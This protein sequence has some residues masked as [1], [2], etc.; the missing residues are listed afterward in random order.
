MISSIIRW[1]VA[2]RYLT[3]AFAAALLAW[4]AV[5]AMRMPVD[6]FPDLTAPSVT[7]IAEAHGMAP[8]EVETQITIPIE[9]ALNGAPGV[10]RTRSTTSVG[11]SV[12]YADFDWGV[13]PLVARQTVSEKLQLARASLPEDLPAPVLAPQTSVM[14]EIMFVALTSKRPGQAAALKTEADWRIRRRLLAVPGVAEVL[15]IGGDERQFQVIAQPERLAAYGLTISDVAEAARGASGSSSEGLVVV[16]AQEYLVQ[17]LARVRSLEDLARSVVAVRGGTPVLLSDVADVQVGRALRRGAGSY[18]A[19]PAVVIGIAK[20]PGTDTLALTQ[21]LDRT[22]AELQRDLPPGMTIA[23]DGFRQAEFINASIRNLEHALRDG[24][25]LV[26]AVVFLFLMSARATFVTLLAIPLSVLAAALALRYAG[27]GINTMTLGGLAIALG[28]LVDDAIIVV[29]NVSRRLRMNAELGEG[30][31]PV[32][33]VVVDATREIQGSIFFA[34][35]IIVLVFLP[36]FALPGVEGRLLAPLALA[37]VVALAASFV[38]AITAT[39][40]LSALMLPKSRAAKPGGEGRVAH[41]VKARYARLLDPLLARWRAAAVVS[42]VLLALAAGGLLVAGRGFLPEFNEGSFT[43][44]A[45]TLPGTSLDQSDALGRLVERTIREVPEVRSTVRRTGRAELDAH[46]QGVEASEID[47]TMNLRGGRPKEA[48]LQDM[49]ERL[50]AVA[51]MNIVIGQPISHRIDHMLSGTRAA[52]AVKVF[53]PDLATLRN[54]AEQV[55]AAAR[56]VPGIADLAVEQQTQIPTLSVAFNREALATYGLTAEQAAA[57][58]DVALAGEEVGKVYEGVTSFNI[59]VRYGEGAAADPAALAALPIPTPSG[60]LVP[61][62]AL[63]EV[64]RDRGPN[65]I[66][67]ENGE[68]KIVV[69]ANAAGRDLVSVVNDLEKRVTAAVRVPPGYRIEYGGQFESA[70]AA[71][72]RLLLM[73]AGVIAGIYL[74]LYAAFRSLRDAALVMLNLPLAL[75]G[76]VFGMWVTGGVLSVATIVGFITLFGIATRNGVMLVGHIRDLIASGE[77]Q[78]REDAVRQGALERV[79]PILMTALAAGLGLVP[80]AL[81]AGQPG[82]EIQAP[83]A[84]VILFGLVTSTALNMIVVPALY[85]RFGDA[86]R[87]RETPASAAPPIPAPAE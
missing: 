80:L 71:T 34:T 55:E 2:N 56:D 54:L 66:G 40:A 86:G 11:S 28:A 57:S 75:V 38:V 60:A 20:Q 19:A 18:N 73:G 82:S 4:G 85:L 7:V 49:R 33:D 9:S 76:G 22:I 39:P 37:Y 27:A 59:A 42:G 26:I 31:R 30:R 50:A 65:M 74:L 47:V 53:G 52:I 63:G 51:G 78:T 48:I 13:D 83:M 84:I 5:E 69:M 21:A 15:V 87:Q 1:S 17:G 23:T 6:V 12:I 16:Q 67:R 3:L 77:A 14:G 29:E 68:R 61:L 25:I 10:R 64:L 41:W 44:A 46:A 35:L 45:V 81:A 8:R 58:L 36:L 24:A 70:S 32:R 43:I 72:Q 62:S 79:V